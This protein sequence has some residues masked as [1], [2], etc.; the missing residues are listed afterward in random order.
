MNEQ[1]LFEQRVPFEG[2]WPRIL[3]D[4]CYFHLIRLMGFD[5]GTL[6]LFLVIWILRIRVH[7]ASQ[8]LN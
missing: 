5:Q 4:C 3:S 7:M 8:S 2:F 6:S 1:G